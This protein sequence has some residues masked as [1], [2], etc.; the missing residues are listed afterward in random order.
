M[1]YGL[2]TGALADAVFSKACWSSSP[3]DY[4]EDWPPEPQT[5]RFAAV[6]FV[7]VQRFRIRGKVPRFIV[8]H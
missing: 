5:R 1:T 2:P 3:V 6:T 4:T 8:K 7:R